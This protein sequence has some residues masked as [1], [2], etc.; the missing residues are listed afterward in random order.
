[1]KKTIIPLALILQCISLASTSSGQTTIYSDD[2]ATDSSLA[3]PPWYNL[4]NTSAASYALN[5]TAGQGLALT[6]TSGSTGKV[7]EMFA[8]FTPV[9]LSAGDSL[10][11]TVLFNS[12]SGMSTDTG[13]LLAGLYNNSTVNSTNEQ[14]STGGGTTA[15][16]ETAASQGY[17]GIM[18]YNTGA[19][20]STKFYSR[21][22]GATD[23]N[24]LGYYSS[25]T[26]GS[27]TQLSSFGAAGNANLGLNINYTL[28][29]T[30]T[31]NGASGNSILATV[32]NG[33][34][35]L[36][37]WTSTDASGLYDTF[38]QLD[39]GNYGKASAVDVNILSESVTEITPT[40]EPAS[41][42]LLGAG[43]GLFGMMR[44]R[45]R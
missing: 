44:F 23:N 11:L 41:L 24:E 16:G 6:V 13:G 4:N 20:T 40:P 37:S 25:M 43:A 39:F 30:I 9:T 34:T 45:R 7:N 17:F 31:D 27:Y 29:F 35:T 36:D 12:P 32:S 5:P 33:S 15:G 1:M 10:S 8:E 19:G 18:G 42:A 21:Q 14:G 38:N 28:Q 2:F 22:G 26:S 3:Q